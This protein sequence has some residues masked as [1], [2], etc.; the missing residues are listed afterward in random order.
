MLFALW[1]YL[2]LCVVA[3]GQSFAQWLD[4][5]GASWFGLGVFWSVG[6]VVV[7]ALPFVE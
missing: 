7:T 3:A 6:F 5:D 4:G 2:P 1:I